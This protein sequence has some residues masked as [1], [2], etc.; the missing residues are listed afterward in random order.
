[1]SLRQHDLRHTAAT[2][3]LRMTGDLKAVQSLMGHST[4]STTLDLYAHVLND[5]LTRA[6]EV[7][8]KGLADAAEI[9]GQGTRE[10]LRRLGESLK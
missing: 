10:A 9:D 2:A 4:A 3:W 6:A 5:T 1:V 8:V 7:M